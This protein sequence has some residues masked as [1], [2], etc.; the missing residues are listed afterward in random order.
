MK[1]QKALS[2]C[3][4][5]GFPEYW[6]HKLT[7]LNERS[8]E[9]CRAKSVTP[10]QISSYYDNFLEKYE[11]KVKDKP[12]H[13]FNLDETGLQPYQKPPNIIAAPNI[14][15]QAIVSPKSTTVTFIGCDNA[16]GNSLPP[17]FVFK[18]KTWNQELMKGASPGARGILSDSG[19][20]NS[21]IFHKTLRNTFCLL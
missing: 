21:T 3:W 15:P 13:I 12:M 14:K 2:N 19:W 5:Y 9:S 1:S 6:K 16:I 4:L 17:Y 18:G 10:E 8:L 7:S 20:S 11:L